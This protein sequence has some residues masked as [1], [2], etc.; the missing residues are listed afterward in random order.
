M[1]EDVGYSPKPE[2]EI[3]FT[4]STAVGG[5]NKDVADHTKVESEAA[6]LGVSL[7]PNPGHGQGGEG[8]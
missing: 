6:A 1:P 2:T 4:Q 5:Y 7:T 3:K 8:H